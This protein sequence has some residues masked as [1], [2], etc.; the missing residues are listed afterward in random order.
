MPLVEHHWR[1]PLIYLEEDLHVYSINST[2]KENK[3]KLLDA[4]NSDSV[5]QK[6]KYYTIHGWPI[7]KSNADKEL[8]QF[9]QVKSHQGVVAC[10]KLANEIMYWPGMSKDLEKL[11]LSCACLAQY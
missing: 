4:I 6:L 9:W 5:L 8:N 3:Q 10:N 2:L 1:N 7:H 11:I